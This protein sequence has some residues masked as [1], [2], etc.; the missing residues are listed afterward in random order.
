M[1]ARVQSRRIRVELK[2]R[3]RA[4]IPA[5]VLDSGWPGPDL[6]KT[7]AQHRNEVQGSA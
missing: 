7:A 5:W 3:R 4:T 2:S 6:L 1:A